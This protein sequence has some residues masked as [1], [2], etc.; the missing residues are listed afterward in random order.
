MMLIPGGTFPM[1]RDDVSSVEGPSHP[2]TLSR[3]HR[4][5]EVTL[6]QYL[7]FHKETGRKDSSG[8]PP[9]PKDGAAP[10]VSED[11]PA[12]MVNARDARAYATWAG[13]V[14]P[15]EAQWEMAARTPDGRI[16]PWGADAPKWGRAREPRQVDPVMSFPTDLSPFGVYDLAGNAME[17]TS[18]IYDTNYHSRFRGAAAFDPTGPATSRTRPPRPPSRAAPHLAG[19]MA[20]GPEARHELPYLGFRW[21]CPSRPRSGP[22]PTPWPNLRYGMSRPVGGS[23][24]F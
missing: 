4:P 14:L 11:H 9:A 3:I 20:R 6:R 21:P 19:L 10:A 22:P 12:T 23:V 8:R 1:G 13:K 18:D 24:A 15:T 16:Y 17:W 2:V 5:H 7:L